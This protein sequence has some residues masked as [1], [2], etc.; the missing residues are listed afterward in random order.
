MCDI[1][2]MPLSYRKTSYILTEHCGK[3]VANLILS[4]VPFKRSSKYQ[5]FSVK[6]WK[7][8]SMANTDGQYQYQYQS[9]SK[10][11]FI[12][13]PVMNSPVFPSLDDIYCIQRRTTLIKAT[14]SLWAT[15]KQKRKCKSLTHITN[16]IATGKNDNYF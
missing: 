10:Y 12:C 9:Y 4:N 1:P 15:L 2:V 11:Q 16:L 3:V 8:V 14:I 7:C 5:Y 13:L 6:I